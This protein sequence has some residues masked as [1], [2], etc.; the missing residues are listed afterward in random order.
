MTGNLLPHW[1]ISWLKQK[2]PGSGG[3]RTVL[4][5]VMLLLP[6]C[7]MSVS[8]CR[9][10]QPA[11]VPADSCVGTVAV[12]FEHGA[13]AVIM[14]HSRGGKTPESVSGLELHG[15]F[16]GICLHSGDDFQ[17]Q[18]QQEKEQKLPKFISKSVFSFDSL[19]RWYI[20]NYADI[21]RRRNNLFLSN[22]DERHAVWF[23]STPFRRVNPALRLGYRADLTF[24]N[25]R[26]RETGKHSLY[27]LWNASGGFNFLYLGGRMRFSTSI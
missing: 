13:G 5:P 16:Y 26:R 20:F 2:F 18:R 6:L 3:S 12:H 10:K 21:K 25:V 7:E 22:A 17:T 1:P 14:F 23:V 27:N 4:Q 24:M 15:L 19:I 9:H 8:R 11:L